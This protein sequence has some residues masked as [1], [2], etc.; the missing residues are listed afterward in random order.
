MDNDEN[1]LIRYFKG[2]SSELEKRQIEE[3]LL[4]DEAF[5]KLANTLK[6]EV[7]IAEILDQQNLANKIKER[8]FNHLY[9]D[10]NRPKAKKKT[11]S[12][13]ILAIIL[14]G[15]FFYFFKASLND[16]EPIKVQEIYAVN[17]S[18]LRSQNGRIEDFEDIQ[19][20]I[21]DRNTDKYAS[22]IRSLQSISIEDSTFLRA[23]YLLGHIYFIQEKYSKSVTAFKNATPKEPGYLQDQCKWYR[24][25]ALLGSNRNED[26]KGLLLELINT[27][28][29]FKAKAEVLLNEI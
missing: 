9:A 2:H 6:V 14:I 28:S 1:T 17:L 23:S 18:N 3:R 21:I 16:Q 29:S 22:S 27:N 5:S 10:E 8:G 24:I 19:R 15:S 20:V 7:H 26:A 12:F 11:L 13:I 4:S 25:L